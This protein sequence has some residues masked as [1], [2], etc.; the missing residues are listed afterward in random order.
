FRDA[1]PDIISLFNAAVE[2]VAM[3]DEPEEQNPVRKK[4]LKESKEWK[5]EGLNDQQAEE[6]ALYRVFGSK[7]G[8]YGAGLQGLIDGKNWQTQEDLAKVYINW[9]GYAYYGDKNEG[10]SAHETFRTR[11]SSVD[12]VTHNQDNREHDILDSDD[13]YQF[14]GGITN[15][16]KSQKGS[17]PQTYFGDHARPE[18]PKVKS[19]KEELLKVYRSRAINPK[20]IKGMKDHGYKGAFEMMATMDYLFAY[21]ATT[22]QVDDFMYEGITES[23]LLDEENRKF[24]EENN[25]WALRDMTER[26]LEAIQRGMWESPNKETLEKLKSIHLNADSILEEKS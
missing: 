3:L 21:D 17:S 20:W 15:A 18:N 6:R 12:A 22:D 1:F 10:R 2:K 16:V 19:L 14:Y 26:M 5:E 25:P 23:Y 4:F 7:P 24:I 8:A 13:Y 9:S 11:L